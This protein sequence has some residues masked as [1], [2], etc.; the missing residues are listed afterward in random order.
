MRSR[1]R[2]KGIMMSSVGDDAPESGARVASD[3]S[4]TSEQGDDHH[5]GGLSELQEQA[6]SALRN[7]ADK[8]ESESKEADAQ[9]AKLTADLK[10]TEARATRSAAEADR[11]RTEADRVATKPDWLTETSADENG[12][13][14]T[15]S[16]P[17]TTQEP[18]AAPGT[19]DATTSSGADETATTTDPSIPGPGPAR[20]FA[21]PARPAQPAEPASD[22]GTASAPGTASPTASGS[23]SED[24]APRPF[25]SWRNQTNS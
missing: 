18:T 16:Q 25:E 6:A 7:L 15:T 3:E 1:V 14:S 8:Y 11:I 2:V 10:A 12:Q 21:Q 17:T 13:E 22:T 24:W 20:G 19:P 4:T 5:N 9:V 23:G